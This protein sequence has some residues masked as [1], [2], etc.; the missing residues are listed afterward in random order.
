MIPC[1]MVTNLPLGE[2]EQLLSSFQIPVL[3]CAASSLSYMG[4]PVQFA[5]VFFLQL[6]SVPLLLA[7]GS[8]Q[9]LDP[10]CWG[11]H[12]TGAIIPT[13]NVCS[14]CVNNQKELQ[15]GRASS[16]STFLVLSLDQ[17]TLP[18]ISLM[19]FGQVLSLFL[20]LNSLWTCSH[21]YWIGCR[22]TEVLS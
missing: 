13:Q 11:M 19:L 14:R 22:E 1:S 15:R 2:A 6:S 5:P 20:I 10:V 17:L 16:C 3:Q 4:T 9:D 21:Y 12:R 7:W 18:R 8:S